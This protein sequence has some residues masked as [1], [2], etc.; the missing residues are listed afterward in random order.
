MKIFAVAHGLGVSLFL[1]KTKQSALKKALKYYGM[2]VGPY[3]CPEPQESE[4]SWAK[5]MGAMVHE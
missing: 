2:G 1:A 3:S 4:I 5:Y